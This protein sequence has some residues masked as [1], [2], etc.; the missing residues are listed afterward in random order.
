MALPR[1]VR[2][3][4]T[5]VEVVVATGIVG[6]TLAALAALV[7]TV[8]LARITQDRGIALAIATDEIERL[9]MGGYSALP[10]TGSFT[11]TLLST[12]PESSAT[13][14]VTAYNANT[15]QVVV[16]VGWKDPHA[17]SQSISLTT[18]VVDTGGLP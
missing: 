18:L 10:A 15:K 11:H 13:V 17:A 2:A 6:A 4:F 16:T 3:G 14:A 7:H 9:R 8:P 1:R 5:L 12:L